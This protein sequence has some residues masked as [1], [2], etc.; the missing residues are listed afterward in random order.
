MQKEEEEINKKEQNEK[1]DREETRL[2][3]GREKERDRFSGRE[4]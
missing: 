3:G 1:T 2:E 4:R